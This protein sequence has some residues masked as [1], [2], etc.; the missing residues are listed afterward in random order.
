MF[1]S[2]ITFSGLGSGIDSASLVSRLVQL[3]GLRKAQLESKKGIAKSKQS[4]LSKLEGLVKKLREQAK[5]ISTSGQ[6][7]KLAGQASREGV[8]S[9][10]VASTAAQGSHT[11]E[12]Q[13]L[14]ALDRWAFDGVADPEV[15]LAGADGE[16]LQFTAGGTTHTITVTAGASSLNEIAAAINDAAGTSVAATVVNVGTQ[17]APSWKL[18]LASKVSGEAGRITGITSA[19]AGL[20]I[21]GSEAAPGSGTPVSANH[22]TVGTNAR[23]LVDGLLVERDS[24]EFSGVLSGITFTAQSTNAG[25]PVELS[26][27]PD[28]TAIRKSLDE[29]VSAYNGVVKFLNEQGTYTAESGAGGALFGDSTL[30]IVGSKMR[31][32]LFNVDLGTVQADTEG[33]S[34]LG[35]VGVGV[36][37][38]GT[39]KIDSS[40]VDQ[41]I[42]DNVA[43]FAALFTDDDGAGT[44]DTGVAARLTAALD[45]VLDRGTGPEGQGLKS[46]FGAK[47]ES[48][49]RIMSELDRRIADEEVRLDKYEETLRMRYANLENLMARLNSQT[50]A[51]AALYQ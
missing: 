34:T 49:T 16:T 36:E 9:F 41:K 11:I 10:D 38:D 50:S 51:L 13:Q 21:D 32:A 25:N 40:K 39:L 42:T 17:S 14:A 24:N 46:L 28:R 19:I 31:L 20:G 27:E 47:S 6:F 33:Y 8:L 44:G 15:D 12:V 18:V 1:G 7:L 45:A 35:L 23:A 3:E 30:S 4:A 29:F 26:I 2:G 48:L 22:V 5:S 37:K 43:A